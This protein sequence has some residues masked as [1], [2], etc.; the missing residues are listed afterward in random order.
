M[1][2]YTLGALVKTLSLGTTSALLEPFKRIL[3]PVMEDEV[4]SDIPRNEIVRVIKVLKTGD[5]AE[6]KSFVIKKDTFDFVSDQYKLSK[7]LISLSKFAR[8]ND[9]YYNHLRKNVALWHEQRPEIFY[10]FFEYNIFYSMKNYYLVKSETKDFRIYYLGSLINNCNK[11]SEMVTTTN[12]AYTTA[13][14]C[15]TVTLL[16][17]VQDETSTKG[18]VLGFGKD[19][20][21]KITPIVGFYNGDIQF[22]PVLQHSPRS[23]GSLKFKTTQSNKRKVVLNFLMSDLLDKSK[24]QYFNLFLRALENRNVKI[25]VN[26]KTENGKING[27]A[28]VTLDSCY[29][30]ID[31]LDRDSKDKTNIKR[32]KDKAYG[33]VGEISNEEFAKFFN[34]RTDR[35]SGSYVQVTKNNKKPVYFGSTLYNVK[36]P[37]NSPETMMTME[38]V[39]HE[40]GMSISAW[41]SFLTKLTVNTNQIAQLESFSREREEDE[42]YKQNARVGKQVLEQHDLSPEVAKISEAITKQFLEGKLNKDTLDKKI[43][44]E[45]LNHPL[46][47][48]ELA[49]I[50]EK[51]NHE[52]NDHKKISGGGKPYVQSGVS[53]L[54]SVF[55]FKKVS[56]IVD[57]YLKV[58][59]IISDE[60]IKYEK[61]ILIF[62]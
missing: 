47:N 26:L 60:E 2:E 48:Y 59:I 28:R 11:M 22:A 1:E 62:K 31:N 54:C 18:R 12:V 24:E 41:M 37:M 27:R 33:R 36:V 10:K 49:K 38:R 46:V 14:R 29:L 35:D 25:E 57:I 13:A 16:E 51:E 17:Q 3:D 23:S 55:L 52:N 30:N 32:E 44:A 61:R 15:I 20:R 21:R 7:D 8:E 43:M 53:L 50:I 40:R 39:A 19:A 42:T 34:D 56:Q 58:F 4:Y 5:L 9:I 6:R 45:I